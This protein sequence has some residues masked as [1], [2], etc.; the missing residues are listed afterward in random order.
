M[1]ALFHLMK[2]K[3]IRI[4]D[5]AT[6]LEVAPNTVWNWRAGNNEPSLVW[7]EKMIAVLGYDIE[8]RKIVCTSKTIRNDFTEINYE[9][10]PE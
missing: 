1:Q 10:E 6:M 3:G 5:M 8:L 2:E 4:R 7:V 9:S